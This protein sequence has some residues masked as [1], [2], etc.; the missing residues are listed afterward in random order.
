MFFLT[1]LIKCGFPS[2]QV[3]PVITCKSFILQRTVFSVISV[4][5]RRER[6]RERERERGGER[7]RERE[8]E[9]ERELSLIHI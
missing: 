2:F 8:S 5:A 1:F 6:E 4:Y 3:H 9:R 7:E